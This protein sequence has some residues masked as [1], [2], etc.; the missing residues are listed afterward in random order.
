M[1]EKLNLAA[2]AAIFVFLLTALQSIAQNKTFIYNGYVS[3]FSLEYQCPLRV[4]YR[5]EAKE[6]DCERGRFYAAEGT[7][8]PDAYFGTGYERGHCA[9]AANFKHD[10]E[11]MEE[12]FS[13]HNVFPQTLFTNRRSWK[14][15]EEYERKLAELEGCVV[16]QVEL[17]C[18]VQ[19]QGLWVPTMLS[20]KVSRCWEPEI[21]FEFITPNLTYEAK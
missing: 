2:T 8:K 11:M 19:S 20:K 9:P 12:S 13:M 10:C 3:H 7:H 17:S 1:R 21:L 14:W 16:V 4:T 5:V 15:T 18:F 6:G